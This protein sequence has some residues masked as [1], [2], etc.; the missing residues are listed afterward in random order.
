MSASIVR[1]PFPKGDILKAR[2]SPESSIPSLY[3]GGLI[4][5]MLNQLEELA[6]NIESSVEVRAKMQTFLQA[7]ITLRRKRWIMSS[8]AGNENVSSPARCP[9]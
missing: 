2:V 4:T 8:A 6:D 9:S 1:V 5:I 7:Y 3:Y